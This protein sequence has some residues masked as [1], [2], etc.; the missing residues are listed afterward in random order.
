MTSF[1]SVDPGT[2]RIGYAVWQRA[3]KPGVAKW[4]S[5]SGTFASRPGTG[6]VV[7]FEERVYEIGEWLEQQARAADKGTVAIET[8]QYFASKAVAARSDSLVKLTFSV[9]YYAAVFKKLGWK[10]HLVRVNHW[11]GT[12]TKK[13]VQ[14]R[15]R[16]LFGGSLPCGSNSPGHD[17]LDAI[18]L[19]L[20]A[21]GVDW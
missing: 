11:K 9:G 8:P 18:A 1:M 10:V 5:V 4:P 7:G 20:F 13:V 14:A 6:N 19:G 15:L 3:L 12:M 2:L 17:E 21:Q 16:L